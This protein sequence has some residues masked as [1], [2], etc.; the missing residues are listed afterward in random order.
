MRHLSVNSLPPPQQGFSLRKCDLRLPAFCSPFLENQGATFVRIECKV[1]KQDPK[2]SQEF[3]T[4]IFNLCLSAV[5]LWAAWSGVLRPWVCSVKQRG[6]PW[7]R[8]G[9]AFYG[10]RYTCLPR[11]QLKKLPFSLSPNLGMSALRFCVIT[12]S[13]PI[14]GVGTAGS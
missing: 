3:S 5:L 1:R 2:V 14:S 7:S 4:G 13:Q 10:R 8:N 11:N 9:T 6:L 12:L